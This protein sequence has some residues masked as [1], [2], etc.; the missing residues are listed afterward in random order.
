MAKRA[1]RRSRKRPATPPESRSAEAITVFWTTTLLATVLGEVGALLSRTIVALTGAQGTLLLLSNLL[2]LIAAVTGLLCLALTPLVLRWRRVPPP[3]KITQF[4]VVFSL[5][6][7]VT[8]LVNL[9][10]L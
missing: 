5:L 10:F 3:A 9:L 2:L 4:A 1:K 8:L 6:P 7:I